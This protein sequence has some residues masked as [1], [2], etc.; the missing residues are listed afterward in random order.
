MALSP[1]SGGVRQKE[2]PVSNVSGAALSNAVLLDLNG[3]LMKKLQPF[4]DSNK[5]HKFGSI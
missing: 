3:F 2:S 4:E 5:M 1:S